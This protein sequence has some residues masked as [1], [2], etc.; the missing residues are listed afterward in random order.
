LSVI[1]TSFRRLFT[2]PFAGGCKEKPGSG[3]TRAREF[4]RIKPSP[5]ERKEK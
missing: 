5:V 3:E 4:G 1:D 2:R